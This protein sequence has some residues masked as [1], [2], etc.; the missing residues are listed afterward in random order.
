MRSAL[1]KRP[2]RA[3]RR[4]DLLEQGQLLFEVKIRRHSVWVQLS[5]L[6]SGHIGN[7]PIIRVGRDI[8]AKALQCPKGMRQERRKKITY[9]QP[10][11]QTRKRADARNRSHAA[12]ADPPFVHSAHPSRNCGS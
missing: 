2:L 8:D 12:L 4:S 7:G 3:I 6:E 5:M 1:R 9:S 11:E 10:D